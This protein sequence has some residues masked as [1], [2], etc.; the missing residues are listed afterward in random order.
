MLALVTHDGCQVR[1]L[2]AYFGETREKPCGHCTYCLSVRAQTLPD[3]EP[4]PDIDG[5]VDRRAIS[6][7]RSE[8]PEALSEP[9]QLARL[10]CGITSPATT[11]AKL[12][13]DPLFGVLA[14]GRF[15]D[16]LRWSVMVSVT[17]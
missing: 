7:L 12:T 15:L 11:R 13:R 6:Q 10:L 3:A 9:R 1:E 17:P 2:A 16:V 8:S 5:L 14:E 4:Q